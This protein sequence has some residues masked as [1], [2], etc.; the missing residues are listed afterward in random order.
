M[1]TPEPFAATRPTAP[2]GYLELLSRAGRLR[3]RVRLGA[4]P[5][6]AGRA[7]HNDLILDDPYVC[8]THAELELAG[9]RLRVRDL[10][11]R[12]GV[13]APGGRRTHD[14]VWV[15]SGQTFQLGRAKLRFRSTGFPVAPAR[16]DRDASWLLRLFE[17]P[18]FLVPLLLGT[19]ALSAW[20]TVLES[21]KRME[22]SAL[23]TRVAGIAL[24][25]VLWTLVWSAATRLAQHRWRFLSHCG[26]ACG[27]LWAS[28]ATETGLLYLVFALQLP[29]A[30][31][32]LLVA[33][34]APALILPLYGHLRFASGAS[35]R[36]LGWIATGVVC[37]LLALV[38]VF[39]YG[40]D[41]PFQDAPE[42]SV[43]LKPPAFLLVRGE[44]PA[45][46]FQRAADLEAVLV[47]ER[48]EKK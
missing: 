47:D 11:S 25:L 2:G 38:A 32:P 3:H 10:G 33:A 31:E 15:A 42:L 16:E 27:A 36:R 34:S 39:Q 6:R 13:V 19:A 29:T 48:T 4:L 46:F 43:P 17:R 1:N 18:G 5:L 8:P 12:N 26:V 45:A 24:G 37:A 9:D 41:D 44:S 21:A 40:V 30:W 35:H 20:L 23:A 14:E 22:P 7:Y 28:A